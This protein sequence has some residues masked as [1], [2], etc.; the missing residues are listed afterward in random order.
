L[1][2]RSDFLKP[3]FRSIPSCSVMMAPGRPYPKRQYKAEQI[4]RALGG[5]AISWLKPRVLPG[6]FHPIIAYL[7]TEWECNLDYKTRP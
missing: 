2:H 4:T 5:W 3:Y 1:S 6:N 7:F